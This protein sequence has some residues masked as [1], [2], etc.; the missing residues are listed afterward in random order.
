MDTRKK[1][2]ILIT[3]ALL[4][5][6]RSIYLDACTGIKKYNMLT[7]VTRSSK[8]S[9]CNSKSY[10]FWSKFL[11]I[12]GFENK[13]F[14]LI[15]KFFLKMQLVYSEKVNSKVFGNLCWY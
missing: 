3:N 12:A 5:C 1:L 9:R 15:L 13:K 6:F 11:S 4:F 10:S 8:S 14:E 7:S 2:A